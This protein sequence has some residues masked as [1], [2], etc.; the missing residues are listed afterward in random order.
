MGGPGG[1][2]SELSRS[3]LA[4]IGRWMQH[5]RFPLR[6]G[7]RSSPL[8]M[9][10]AEMVKAAL[11]GR[12]GWADE[13][14]QLVPV[15]ASGDKIQ[16]RHLAEVG[17]KALWTKELDYWLDSG[18]IDFAVHSLKDVETIRPDAFVIAAMLPRADV[19]DRLIGAVSLEAIAVGAK[20][21]TSA[22]RR[23]AQLL[24]MRPDLEITLFR[25]NVHT[26][27]K[28]LADG[29]VAATMLAG[30]GLDRLGLTELGQPIPVDIMLPA[31]SQGAIGI[32]CLVANTPMRGWLGAINDQITHECVSAERL[33]LAALSGDCRSPVAALCVVR[34]D[35]LWLRAQILTLDGLEMAEGEA[36]F[37]P[38]DTDAPRQL[39]ESLLADASP[40]LRAAFG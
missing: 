23:T 4:A 31:P 25:G 15:I 16:D 10:Q 2:L 32:E 8:A 37:A 12:H 18:E 1:K 29:E 14:V 3:K 21:G 20:L 6:L 26:R 11:L 17:G 5:S 27:L 38:G 33:L 19:R 30:A 36:V 35:E 39:A 28:K 22:P 34:G 7:T 24:R 40:A 9:A 13:D